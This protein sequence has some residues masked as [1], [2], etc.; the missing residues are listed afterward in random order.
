MSDRVY[1]LNE[2]NDYLMNKTAD[3]PISISEFNDVSKSLN[4]ELMEGP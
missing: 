2:M 3:I 4:L 1:E